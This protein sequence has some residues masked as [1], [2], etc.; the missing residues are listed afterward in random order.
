MAHYMDT[1]D[2]IAH[3]V[4]TLLSVAPAGFALILHMGFVTPTILLQSYSSKWQDHYN[5]NGYA[6][7]DPVVRWGF[8]NRGATTWASLADDDPSGVLKAAAEHGMTHGIVC[9]VGD[10]TAFSFCGYARNDRAFTEE[11][12]ALLSKITQKLHDLTHGLTALPDD[13][14][15]AIKALSVDYT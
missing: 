14:A 6:M 3:Q 2:E 12:T 11:E 7:T 4:E 10:Q 1:Q 5:N 13:T 8:S 15:Q 9:S